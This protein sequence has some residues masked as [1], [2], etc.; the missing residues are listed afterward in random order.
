M[1]REQLNLATVLL[2]AAVWYRP[3]QDGM[4]KQLQQMTDVLYEFGDWRADVQ[5]P[6]VWSDASV[7]LT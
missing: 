4:D 1:T 6:Q 3:G 2:G 7:L 5:L